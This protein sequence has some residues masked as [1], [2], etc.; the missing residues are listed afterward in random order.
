MT[1]LPDLGA[2][3]S[4]T[5]AT[6]EE[7]VRAG[8][9]RS[10]GVS[11]ESAWGVMDFVARASCDQLRPASIQNAYNLLNRKFELS[12]AEVAFREGVGLLAY[13]PIAAGVLTGKYLNGSKPAGARMTLWPHQDR[14]FNPRAQA[15]TASYVQLAKDWGIAPEVLAHAF[16]LTRPFVTASV[17]G[18]TAVQ[19]L[20]QAFAALEFDLTEE[21][22]TKLEAMHKEYLVP[23]P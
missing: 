14:Y 18:G 3:R 12:L 8:K 20:D 10:W 4:E 9:I 17:V 1:S 21:L 7:L 19:H 13:A 22:E 11:N 6:L 5:L 15:G 2:D 16:V 23:A